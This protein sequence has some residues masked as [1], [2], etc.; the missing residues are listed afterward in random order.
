MSASQAIEKTQL[1][2][3]N[4]HRALY[5]FDEL[6]KSDPMLAKF[7]S[8]NKYNNLSI[9]FSD[10]AAV[11]ELN[12]ALLQYYYGIDHWDIP[13]N[14]LC[15]PIPG[16]ADHIHYLAD[17][18]ASCNNGIIPL[19]KNVRCLD[20]GTGANC[21]YPIIGNKEYGWQFVGTETDTTAIRS[22]KR[23][24][25]ANA[26]LS[27][28]VVIRQQNDP[29]YIF[30]GIIQSSETFDVSI[31][32]PPF[33]TS[34]AEAQK[35][36]MRKVNNLGTKKIGNPI[37][38]FGGQNAELWCKG[39]ESGFIARMIRESSDIKTSCFW[40][41]SLVSKSANLR[42]IYNELKKVEPFEIR[43]IDMAQGNKTSRI[44]AWTYLNSAQQL[45]WREKRWHPTKK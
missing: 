22:A 19:N 45:A 27:T 12:K 28:N 14:Y 34:L 33:H 26:S 20:I 11:K 29:E 24:I 3:R 8:L 40:F 17:L 39:G 2:P 37:L 5:A 16:R 32:N 31:C 35:G 38:N 44:V 25:A 36:T 6:I 43:T 42:G 4:K 7:V 21:I 1:H 9:D 23:I 30:R 18:L 13:K 15:P 41:T 10:P